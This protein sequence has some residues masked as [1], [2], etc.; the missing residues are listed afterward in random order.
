MTEP[1]RRNDRD[2]KNYE[3]LKPHKSQ[4][5]G[6]PASVKSVSL[7]DNGIRGG[8]MP[9]QSNMPMNMGQM[10][11]P[12]LPPPGQGDYA[13]MLPQLMHH[14]QLQAQMTLA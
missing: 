10:P 5:Q 12:G 9:P 8:P 7:K 13:A 1:S 2:D 6:H 3:Q 14:D 11:M 4:T